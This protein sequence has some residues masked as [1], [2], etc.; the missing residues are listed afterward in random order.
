[1]TFYT[2][3]ILQKCKVDIWNFAQIHQKRPRIY[4]NFSKYL[5]ATH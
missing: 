4:V 1:L 3:D 5:Q 2:I